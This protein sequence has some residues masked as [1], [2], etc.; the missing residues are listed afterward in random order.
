MTAGMYLPEVV[1]PEEWLAAR[2][3]LLAKEKEL[4]RLRARHRRADRPGRRLEPCRQCLASP[5]TLGPAIRPRHY[6]EA[7]SVGTC[8]I[9][10]QLCG[11]SENCVKRKS[12]FGVGRLTEVQPPKALRRHDLRTPS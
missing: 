2:R 1:S 12:N 9:G 8:S 10:A 11:T 4:T 5:A 6:V 3:E 7:C